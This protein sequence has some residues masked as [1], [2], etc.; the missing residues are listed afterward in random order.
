M[1]LFGLAGLEPASIWEALATLHVRLVKMSWLITHSKAGGVLARRQ[2]LPEEAFISVEELKRMFGQGNRDGV[3]PIIAISFCW[4]TPAHADPQ[5]KQLATVAAMLAREKAKYSEMGFVDMGVFWDCKSLGLDP[6]SALWP[7][8]PCLWC[9]ICLLDSPRC[10]AH[11]ERSINCA[12]RSAGASLYQKDPALWTPACMKAECDRTHTEAA[13][14]ARYEASRTDQQ[15]E[16]F[17]YALEET[18]DLWYAHQGTTVYMLTKL[19]EGS[20]RSI[21]YSDSGWERRL[22]S[23]HTSLL[24]CPTPC[25]AVERA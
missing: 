3:L 4:D 7:A 22:D 2:E 16:S 25:A 9:M 12:C 13:D 19:P 8:R 17:G 6:S 18:M 5:G 14:V 11:P 10:C 24:H 23:N 1:A 20:E 15:K 21:G